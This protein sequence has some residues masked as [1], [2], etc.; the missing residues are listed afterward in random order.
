MCWLYYDFWFEFDGMLKLWVV[1][2]GLS[3]DL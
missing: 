2:K 3:F 1:L